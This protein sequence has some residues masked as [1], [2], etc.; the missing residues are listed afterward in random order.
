MEYSGGTSLDVYARSNNAIPLVLLQSYLQGLLQALKY[1][2]YNSIVHKNLR[3]RFS[4]DQNSIICL[5]W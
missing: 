2:H 1:L 4:V 3:V 5:F